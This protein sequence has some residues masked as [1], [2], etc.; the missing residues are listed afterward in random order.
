MC[1]FVMHIF[2]CLGYLDM[3]DISLLGTPYMNVS[4]GTNGEVAVSS[5]AAAD[6]AG[7]LCISVPASGAGGLLQPTT[8]RRKS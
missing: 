7:M 3:L 5:L 2:I 4:S 8:I 1:V 6:L